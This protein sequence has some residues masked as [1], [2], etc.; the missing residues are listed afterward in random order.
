MFTEEATKEPPEFCVSVIH[1]GVGLP[2]KCISHLAV[3][4]YCIG[5]VDLFNGTVDY[6]FNDKDNATAFSEIITSHAIK[7]KKP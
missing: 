7:S 5:E 2:L 4:C 6:T 3:E 1:K